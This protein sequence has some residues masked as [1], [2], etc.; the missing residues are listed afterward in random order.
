VDPCARDQSGHSPLH[1]A[2]LLALARNEGS[3]SPVDIIDFVAIMVSIYLN[4][5]EYIAESVPSYLKDALINAGA[6]L[7]TTDIPMLKSKSFLSHA[8]CLDNIH[9]LSTLVKFRKKSIDLN[10]IEYGLYSHYLFIL[11]LT[12]IALSLVECQ[13]VK[14]EVFLLL[15]FLWIGL[16]FN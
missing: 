10:A 2:L 15:Q 3:N 11:S 5:L 16:D 8:I 14:S 4:T 1:L 7:D 13:F 9:L 6:S 12:E